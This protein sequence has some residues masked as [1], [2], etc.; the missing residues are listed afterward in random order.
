MVKPVTCAS[1]SVDWPLRASLRAL[2]LASRVCS[3]VDH[4]A[5]TPSGMED[6]RGLHIEMHDV[7]CPGVVPPVAPGQRLQALSRA[8]GDSC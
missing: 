7:S 8:A 6:I 3:P 5:E 2:R 4:A 1:G